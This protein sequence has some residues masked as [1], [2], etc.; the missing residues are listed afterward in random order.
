MK[1]EYAKPEV[2][3]IELE[4]KHSVTM[5]I[6]DSKSGDIPD[7]VGTPF[8]AAAFPCLEELTPGSYALLGQ[9]GTQAKNFGQANEFLPVDS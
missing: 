6:R 7:V 5:A 1:K 4:E 2:T 3:K 9:A 8:D